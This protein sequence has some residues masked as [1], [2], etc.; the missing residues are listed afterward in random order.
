VLWCPARCVEVDHEAIS[1][2]GV[3]SLVA[4]CGLCI[5]LVVASSVVLQ[6]LASMESELFYLARAFLFQ[7]MWNAETERLHDEVARPRCCATTFSEFQRIFG[8]IRRLSRALYTLRAFSPQEMNP[9]TVGTSSFG[10]AHSPSQHSSFLSPLMGLERVPYVVGSDGLS[11]LWRVPVTT[12]FIVLDPAL[13]N[14]QLQDATSMHRNHRA[15]LEI[16][17]KH[18]ATF[19]GQVHGWRDLVAFVA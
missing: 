18:I 13:F 16:F 14:P 6:S 15:I 11:G 8:A 1:V 19:S 10:E 4:T 7:S 5:I 17:Q 9:A 2:E 12:V 3:I